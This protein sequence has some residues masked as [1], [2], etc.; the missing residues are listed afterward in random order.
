[1]NDDSLDVAEWIE[2]AQGDYYAAGILA[3]SD[4]PFYK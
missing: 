3:A 4:N 2:K 1:M